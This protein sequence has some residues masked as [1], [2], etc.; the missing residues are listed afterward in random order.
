MSSAERMRR[1]RAR[2]R[3]AGELVFVRQDWSLFLDPTRLPQKAGCSMSEL[4]A[5]VLKEIVDNGLD[6]GGTVT[7]EQVDLDTWAITDDGPDSSRPDRHPVLPQP[8][9]GQLQAP[10]PTD[11]RHDRQRAARRLGCRGR[12]RW[13]AW[14][15]SRGRRYE[16]VTDRTT[17]ASRAVPAP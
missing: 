13:A 5:L 9:A 10:T 2:Q 8:T 17:G 14:V 7:L 11:A 3:I 16:V 12:V 6:P 4:R 1:L 15:E